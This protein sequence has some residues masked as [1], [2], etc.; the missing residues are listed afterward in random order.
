MLI[1]VSIDVEN[2]C[3]IHFYGMVHIPIDSNALIYFNLTGRA[4]GLLCKFVQ[5]IR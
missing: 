3:L 1:W 2:S 5:V 4:F